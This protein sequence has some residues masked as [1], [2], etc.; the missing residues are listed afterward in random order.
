MLST[1]MPINS[2]L[3][4]TLP[5]PPAQGIGLAQHP[6]V[7]IMVLW[8]HFSLNKVRIGYKGPRNPQV[9]QFFREKNQPVTVTR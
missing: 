3:T 4:A 8:W 7:S 9:S 2:V 5:V 1:L 6:L